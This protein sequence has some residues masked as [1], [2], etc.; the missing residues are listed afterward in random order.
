MYGWLGLDP[1]EWCAVSWRS[2]TSLVVV[3]CFVQ[4]GV[5]GGVFGVANVTCSFAVVDCE[6]C[7]G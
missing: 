4:H 1:V 6:G 5:M 2:V 7:L 3:V